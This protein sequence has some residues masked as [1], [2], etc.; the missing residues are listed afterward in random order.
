[1]RKFNK[2]LTNVYSML[3]EYFSMKCTPTFPSFYVIGIK[4][5]QHLNN[6]ALLS[7]REHVCLQKSSFILLDDDA[8][9]YLFSPIDTAMFALYDCLTSYSQV[10]FILKHSGWVRYIEFAFE[11]SGWNKR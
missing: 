11:I 4:W 3:L 5:E 9:L 7:K 6:N 8:I 10:I 1:M 2:Q